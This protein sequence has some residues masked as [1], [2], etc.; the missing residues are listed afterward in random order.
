MIKKYLFAFI[1]LTLTNFITAQE[2]EIKV[3]IQTPKLKVAD[4]R[5]FQQMEK[6]INDFY[7]KSKWSSDEFQDH[8]KIE[9]N[10]IINI[11]NDLSTNSFV[12]DFSLQCLRPVYKSSYKTQIFNWLDKNYAFTFEEMQPLNISTNVFIDDLTAILT[13]YGYMM[14]GVDYDTYS[15]FGGTQFFEKAREVVENVPLTN[16]NIKTWNSQGKDNN[17]YWLVDN[18]LNAKYRNY[19]QSVYEYHRLGL[20][21]MYEEQE[22]GRAVITSTLKEIKIVNDLDPNNPIVV[23]FMN[24]KKTELIE[25]FKVAG[26]AQRSS[27]YALLS[28]IDPSGI[29]DYK[30]LMK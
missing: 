27:M 24:S 11:T 18:M 17:K 14:L 25:I 19:R 23:L 16:Q 9:A 29:D 10:L 6:T 28:E 13:Y 21:V 8:E 7:N 30:E 15:H 4:A 12:G 22:K 20:D 1:L 2:F 5:L 3:R 26:Y